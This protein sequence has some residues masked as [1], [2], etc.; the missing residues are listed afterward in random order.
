MINVCYLSK[1]GISCDAKEVVMT[2][3]ELL[4]NVIRVQIA[5]IDI[6][7]RVPDGT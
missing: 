2:R 3:F 4:E 7:N 1:I 6:I 5:G